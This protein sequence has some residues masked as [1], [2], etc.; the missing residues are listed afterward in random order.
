MS[1]TTSLTRTFLADRV[2]SADREATLLRRIRSFLSTI[3]PAPSEDA[4]IE[5]YLANIHPALPVLPISSSHSIDSLPPTLRAVILVDSLASFP[6]H[7]A[8]SVYAWRMLKEEH[9]GERA[10]DQPKLSGL[11]TAVLELGTTLDQR[12]DYGLL[13]R[14]RHLPPPFFLSLLGR[15]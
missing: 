5:H 12:G 11:A 3:V 8:A 7:K 10:L 6:Q 15:S 1:S 9:V 2:A 13:A 4:L 14:V